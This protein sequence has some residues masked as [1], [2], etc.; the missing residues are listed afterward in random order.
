MA[1]P[2]T[3][4]GAK[5]SYAFE[6]VAN[7]RPTT[8]YKKFPMI[9]EIPEMNPTPE[10]LDTTSLDNL[11]Y[12][13]GVPGLKSLDT[14]TFNARVSQALFDLYEG[15]DGIISQYKTAN[16]SGLSMWICIDIEGLSKSCYIA[17][18]PSELGMPAVSTNSVVDVSLYFT[19]IG[20]P[21][22]DADPTYATAD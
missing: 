2:L 4:I 12:T 3:S 20:E 15:T 14:L 1:I 13:T 18:E 10:M 19:P 17:V 8:G 11:E 9:T 5:V 6:T 22:W 7:T 16:A 21:A